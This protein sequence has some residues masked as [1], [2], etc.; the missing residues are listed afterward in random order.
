[1]DN[2]QRFAIL[3]ENKKIIKAMCPSITNQSGIYIFF[4]ENEKGEKCAYVGQAKHLLDRI[5]QHL[6]GRKQHIDK[7]LYVHKLY[8]QDNPNGWRFKVLCYCDE[9]SLDSCEQHYI[10]RAI[11]FYDKIYNVTG[12]GQIDKAGD[13]GERYEVKLKTYKNGKN[14]AYNKAKE[15]VKTMF[16]KYLD[17]SIKGKTTKIKERKLKEFEEYLRG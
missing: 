3:N 10:Q 4:R 5:S 16:D 15:Y 12:G 9:E 2:K 14:I 13:I 8:S 17:Y 7:S 11:K 6:M 1:M